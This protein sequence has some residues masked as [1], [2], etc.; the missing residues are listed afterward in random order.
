MDGKLL[1]IDTKNILKTML[2]PGRNLIVALLV[3]LAYL[4]TGPYGIGVG[5]EVNR[6]IIH[7]TSS[8][9]QP[10]RVPAR[11]TIS[12]SRVRVGEW[13]I[14]N[15]DAP[16]GVNRPLFRVNFGDGREELTRNRQIDHKYGRVG[17]YDVHAWVEPD[18]SRPSSV[19]RVFLSV[20]QNSIALGAPATFN[21]QLDRKYR[22][23]KYRF[24]FGDKDQTPWQ[25][26]P[27]TSHAY[28][29]A[30]TFSAHVDIG[31]E[32]NGA[33]KLLGSSTPQSVQVN[34]QRPDSVMLIASPTAVEIGDPVTFNARALT[35]RS[36]SQLPI[37]VW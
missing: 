1:P 31:A 26:Q 9:S 5:Q 13:V 15:L 25:D 8:Q 29:L 24:V 2:P 33:F 34:T 37:C 14:V 35:Q 16:A 28:S 12:K 21:A 20:N 19:P 36:E 6:V 7:A 27:Q 30:Q 23:V 11:V 22:R 3:L 10:G 18:V 4:P 32:E 17:H